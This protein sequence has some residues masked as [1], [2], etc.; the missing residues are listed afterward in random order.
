[1]SSTVKQKQ[2]SVG[3][4]TSISRLSSMLPSNTFA[5]GVAV[6]AGG[7][8]ISKGLTIAVS[9]ILTR[10]YSPD[11]FGLLAVYS[12]F[13]TITTVWA[14]LQYQRAIPL[15]EDDA[16]AANLF[17]VTAT[18]TFVTAFMVLIG[19]AIGGEAI[20]SLLNVPAI[21]P[22]L[23]LLPASILLLG[24][25]QA[26][27]YWTVRRKRY[28]IIARTEVSQATGAAV[29]QVGVGFLFGGPIG[30]VLGQV[31]GQSAGISSLAREAWRTERGLLNAMNLPQMMKMARRY[32]QFPLFTTWSQAFNAVSLQSPALLLT[33]F[34]GPVV[35]GLYALSYKVMQAP[36]TLLGKSISDVFLSGAA[37]AK[38]SGALTRQA[39]VLFNRLL[40]VGLPLLAIVGLTAEPIFGVVFGEEWR[41]AGRYAQWLTPWLFFSFLGN[42]LGPL[43]IVY[44]KQH[45]EL[46]FQALLVGV[47]L[48]AIIIGGMY[49][50][51]VDLTLIMFALGS[52]VCLCGRIFWLL[53]ISGTHSGHTLLAFGRAALRALPVIGIVLIP[54]LL[55]DNRYLTLGAA[56]AGIGLLVYRLDIRTFLGGSKT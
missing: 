21:H 2:E 52:A 10:I 45:I 46:R 49:L 23:W 31:L 5:R 35:T 3:G 8:V 51:D 40:Q 7:S 16:E 22:Y 41:V 19:L 44:E 43:A 48:S 42:P 47:R 37:E 12:A 30:L 9:P 28:S 26:F 15:P 50:K 17:A 36:L 6:I 34:F 11:D 54:M 27:R 13:L 29:T 38:R 24:T 4:E 55:F 25:Y 18:T 53:S 32:K 14:T 39:Y 1:M 56:V 20:G 33:Y